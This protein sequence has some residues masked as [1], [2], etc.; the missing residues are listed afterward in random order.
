[1]SDINIRSRLCGPRKGKAWERPHINIRRRLCGPSRGKVGRNS[2]NVR[3]LVL[4]GHIIGC[5]VQ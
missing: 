4:T 2:R 5:Q 3:V 1:M